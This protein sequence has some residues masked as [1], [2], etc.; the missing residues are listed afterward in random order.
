MFMGGK[1]E[2][3]KKNLLHPAFC[4]LSE[5]TNITKSITALRF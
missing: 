5:T 3:G 4:G 2:K 1:T